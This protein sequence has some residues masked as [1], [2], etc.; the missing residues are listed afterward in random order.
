M[1]TLKV[2]A[3]TDTS[4]GNTTTINSCT[5]T[6]YNTMGK[7][8]II[9]GDMRIDQRN[10]GAAVTVNDNAAFYSVDRFRLMG[11]S[12]DGVFTAQ[13]SSTAPAGFVNSLL[14]TVTTADASVGTTERYRVQHR[15]EGN[16]IADLGWGTANA[17]TVTLSFWVRSSVTGTF[18]GSLI[19]ETGTRSYPFSYTISSANTFEQKTITVAGDTTGTWLTT[20]GVGINVLWSFGMG[21]QFQNTANAW[22]AGDYE[23]VTG[24]T[25]LIATNGATW[26][27]TG[28]Q[29]EVGSVA[30]EF[31]RR[32][33]NTELALCQRYFQTWGGTNNYELMPFFGIGFSTNTVEGPFTFIQPMR[34]APT[35]STAGTL[36]FLDVAAFYSVGTLILDSAG[37]QTARVRTS[38]SSGITQ[39][40]PYQ[41]LANNSLAARIQLS[42]EL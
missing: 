14:V 41:L 2:S 4:G 32:P 22:A 13:Q 35:L 15:I 40:R 28:V 5:P 17:K 39:Y 3:I 25:Q 30:T 31:E 6:V 42:S 8:R 26:Y 7:N 18:G 11:V 37:L 20:T 1:S 33:Y 19:N 29:L 38:T 16:N 34:A 23:T 9:N 36:G 27:I 24:E 10:A 12:S 21:S